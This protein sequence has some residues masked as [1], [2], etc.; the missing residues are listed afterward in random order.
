MKLT[1]KT[2][3][4]GKFVVECEPTQ[5]VSEAKV[6]IVSSYIFQDKYFRDFASIFLNWYAYLPS[7]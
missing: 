5:T 4:G 3:K 2:L 1:V 6:I 7:H